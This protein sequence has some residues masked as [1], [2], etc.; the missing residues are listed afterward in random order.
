MTVGRSNTDVLGSNPTPG[1]DI[2]VLVEP[3]GSR[4]WCTIIRITGVLD[5]THHPVILGII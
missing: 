1:M 3:K 5:V 2:C 4:R